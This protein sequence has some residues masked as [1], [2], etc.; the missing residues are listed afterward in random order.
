MNKTTK[1]TGFLYLLMVPFAI[2][3]V[4]YIPSVLIVPGDATITANNIMNSGG[5]FLGGI[6]SWLICQTIFVFLVL[7]GFEIAFS[8]VTGIGEFIFPLSLLVRGVKSPS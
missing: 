8:P 1:V 7:P 3:S 2:F 4:M 6:A 5:L